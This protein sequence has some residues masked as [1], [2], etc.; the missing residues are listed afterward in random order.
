MLNNRWLTVSL[1]LGLLITVSLVSSIPTYTSSVLHK[2]LVGELEDYK[3]EKQEYPGEFTFS[4]NFSKDDDINRL[5]TLKTVEEL[6]QEIIN[7]TELPK[8]T[9]VTILS[10]SPQRV[11]LQGEPQEKSARILSLSNIEDHIK[12]TDGKLP[13]EKQVE[14]VYEVLV[15]EKALLDRE[16]VVGNILTIG[17]G[18]SEYQ[19][20]PVGTFTVKDTNDPYWTLS[21][22]AYSQDFI[23]S[24]ALFKNNLLKND[25]DLLETSKFVT[26]FDY[27]AF[28]STDIP[29]LLNLERRVN[30]EVSTLMETIIL[31]DFP[32]QD[33]LSTYLQKGEQLKTMLWSFTCFNYACYLFIYGLSFN[34]S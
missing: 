7:D 30:A 8:L 17:E 18:E 16:M 27:T 13:S 1:F 2:L 24:E 3:I 33:I 34:C 26:A 20:Q 11:Q 23:I 29:Q 31:V 5:S 6:N 32:I 21:P 9:E 25:G 14:G 4:V 22:N 12:L 15:P 28:K 10:T 19:V